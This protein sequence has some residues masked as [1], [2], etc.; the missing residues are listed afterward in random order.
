MLRSLTVKDF[1]IVE[2]ISLD[3]QAGFTVLTGETGAGK[4]L[5]LDA[6]SLLLG[7]RTEG[8]EVREGADRAEI[9]AEFDILTCPEIA[10]WLEES[11]LDGDKDVLLMRRLLEKSGRSRS[12]INGQAATLFQLRQLG[13]RLVDIHG[14]NTHHSLIKAEAQ[15]NL[16]DAYAHSTA[17]ACEVTK[18]WHDCQAACRAEADAERLSE[19]STIQRERLTWQINDLETL[20]LEPDEWI[21]LNES[22]SE[23]A[24]VAELKQGVQLMV[25]SMS[26]ID[27]SCLAML[28]KVQAKLFKLANLDPRL[29][30]TLSLLNSADAELR[31]V[32]RRLHDYTGNIEENPGQLR[33]VENRLD[34]LMST[35]RKYRVQPQELHEKLSDWQQQLQALEVSADI[36][37]LALTKTAALAR[38][39]AQAK[40]LSVR[41]HKAARELSARITEEMQ[42]LSMSGA[43]FS[44][45]LTSL[46]EPNAHGLESIEYMVTTNAGAGLRPPN[47][48]ASGGELARISLAI[49]V[50][51][52]E[53]TCVP[54]L[55][56]DEVDVGIGGHVAEVI[57]DMLRELG[58]RYQVLCI[59]HLPQVASCG[60]H[61]WRVS[62][63][64]HKGQVKSH[65]ELLD[66]DQRV[67][68]IARMLSGMKQTK[69]TRE[70]ASEMLSSHE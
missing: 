12:F 8:T 27:N 66:R 47:R 64:E 68:E 65:I 51:I 35:A 42:N 49:Q 38:Y 57:G 4:S 32:T 19:E 45:E 1:V 41:R 25:E 34:I 10:T 48:V 43:N 29:L 63:R 31:E 16:L 60:Q 28:S 54:T 58:Q 20:K 67:L 26:E 69:I 37:M 7:G 62:K 6:L 17:L 52:N 36:E 22:H 33:E 13:E 5:L 61:H 46:P 11:G 50:A 3:F 14:Q 24:H 2:N 40:A 23:L 21:R 44:I 70:H 59:T 53:V 30:E 9:I 18:A 15:R 56:F 55:V 39:H